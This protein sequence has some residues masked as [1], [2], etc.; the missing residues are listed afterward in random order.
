MMSTR[1]N[2]APA[3][4]LG[5]ALAAAAAAAGCRLLTASPPFQYLSAGLV[6][7]KTD[8][9][10]LVG[11]H[12]SVR[13]L[14]NRDISAL[15]ASFSLFD[16]EGNQLPKPGDNYF[17]LAYSEAIPAGT[18]WDICTSLDTAFFY[19]PEIT[20]VA[21]RFRIYRVEFA[22]GSS[23]SDPLALYCFPYDITSQTFGRTEANL[24]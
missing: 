21:E 10:E 24:R 8:C 18:E 16:S 1:H 4:C 12:Y 11:I 23:W 9:H 5:I 7:G 15:H 14:A 2:F 6:V 3:L 17:D 22:D 19:R 13:N 20:L